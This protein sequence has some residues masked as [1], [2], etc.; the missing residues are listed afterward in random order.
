MNNTEK[1]E[2][3]KLKKE[4]FIDKIQKLEHH[5][6]DLKGQVRDLK[7]QIKKYKYIIDGKK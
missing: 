4:E 7:K 1:I 6:F 5:I 3:T 2:L